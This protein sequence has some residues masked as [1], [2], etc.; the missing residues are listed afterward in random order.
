MF[1]SL[2]VVAA[3][4]NSIEA[5]WD[6][7]LK[8]FSYDLTAYSRSVKLAVLGIAV[9][10]CLAMINRLLSRLLDKLLPKGPAN[11]T[12]ATENGNVRS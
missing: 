8:H 9:F 3:I 5:T 12:P 6:L 10:I 11:R 7:S 2:A 4:A 1:T